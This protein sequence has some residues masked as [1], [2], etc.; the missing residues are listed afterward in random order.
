MATVTSNR[1]Q[2]AKALLGLGTTF[3]LRRRWRGGKNRLGDDLI[4][5]AAVAI[6]ERTVRGQA[7]PGG[8][9]L[10]RL[11]PRTVRRKARLGLD[12]RILIETHEMLDLQQVRGQTSV[13]SDTAVMR[14]GLDEETRAKVEFAHEGGPNRPPRPFYDLGKEGQAAADVLFME[15]VDDAV[16]TA[17]RV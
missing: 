1:I 2:V 16:K 9:P 4:D 6:T 3:S 17:E 15:V 8:R 12:T 5:A 11:K 13:T 7:D 10:V 14:A